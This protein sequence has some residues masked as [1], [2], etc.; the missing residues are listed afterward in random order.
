MFNQNMK[1]TRV[2]HIF[3]VVLFVLSIAQISSIVATD[4]GPDAYDCLDIED[5]LRNDKLALDEVKRIIQAGKQQFD[6]SCIQVLTR[7]N[8]F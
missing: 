8:L 6:L 3:F 5:N 2:I 1:M 7:N 4:S